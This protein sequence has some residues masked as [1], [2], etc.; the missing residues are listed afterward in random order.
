MLSLSQFAFLN[1]TILI[2]M[3]GSNPPESSALGV[4]QRDQGNNDYVQRQVPEFGSCQ[5]GRSHD[6]AWQT[7]CSC[8][9]C[10]PGSQI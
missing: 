3:R 2:V 9:D 1:V 8:T 6:R 10:D 5:Q 7:S 4:Q